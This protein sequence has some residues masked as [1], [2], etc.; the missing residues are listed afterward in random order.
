MH[1]STVLYMGIYIVP[2]VLISTYIHTYIYDEAGAEDY[3][4]NKGLV[5]YILSFHFV[6][7]S[8]PCETQVNSIYLPIL[9]LNYH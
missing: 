4:D 1:I 8:K 2:E 6:T 9:M 5:K 7:H 3:G